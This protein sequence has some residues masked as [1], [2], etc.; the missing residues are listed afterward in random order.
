MNRLKLYKVEAEFLDLLREIEPKVSLLKERRPFLGILIKLDEF[1][2]LAP[3]T[4]PKIK[5]KSMKNSEDFIKIDSGNYGAINLNNMIPVPELKYDEININE[6]KDEAYKILLQNQ[7][8][9]CNK[10]KEN[11]LKKAS[12]LRD[13]KLNNKLREDLDKRVCDFKKLEK[14]II[15]I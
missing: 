8:T 7:L 13:K 4:S 15:S 10:N 3:L 1:N 9:W 12:I 14:F 6:E 11:I 5:H 2:Y